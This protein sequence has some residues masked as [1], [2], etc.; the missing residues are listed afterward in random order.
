MSKY[1]TKDEFANSLSHI[2][3]RI[4]SIVEHIAD[5]GESV[6]TNEMLDRINEYLE[7]KLRKIIKADI[8]IGDVLHSNKQK[9]TDRNG[10]EL[11]VGDIVERDND[12]YPVCGID[13][14]SI[15][16]ND[17]NWFLAKNFVLHTR[18]N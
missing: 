11:R 9:A 15:R 6:A 2:N 14:S 8:P 12:L 13:D 7:S 16:V 1:I 18:H 10:T 4:N 17:C 5:L 3:N